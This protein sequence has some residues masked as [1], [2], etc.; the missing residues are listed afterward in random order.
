[1]EKIRVLV[2][3]DENIEREGIAAILS[4]QPDMEVVGQAGDGIRAVELA[5]KLQPDLIL[6]DIAMPRRDG[7]STIPIL[8]KQVPHSRILMLSSFADPGLASQAIKG[9]ALG[10]LYIDATRDQLL[11]AIRDV[12]RGQTYIQPSVG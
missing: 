12:A 9:G 10:F 5:E 4:L 1:M 6:L 2:V 7:L 11:Q 8:R 3:D